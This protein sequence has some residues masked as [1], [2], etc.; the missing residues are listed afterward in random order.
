MSRWGYAVP[1]LRA[2]DVIASRLHPAVTSQLVVKTWRRREVVGLQRDPLAVSIPRIVVMQ[3]GSK[4]KLLILSEYVNNTREDM[5]DVNNCEQLQRKWNIVRYF[6][7]K[8]FT[9]QL[10]SV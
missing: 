8:Y 4:S 1:T 2:S 7:V 6:Y 9:L 3:G 10:F 5:K